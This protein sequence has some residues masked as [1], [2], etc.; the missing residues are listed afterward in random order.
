MDKIILYYIFWVNYILK[1]NGISVLSIEFV[2]TT[3]RNQKIILL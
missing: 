3:S 2:P 1:S